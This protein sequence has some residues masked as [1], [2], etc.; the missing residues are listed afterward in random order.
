MA[1]TSFLISI[2]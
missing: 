2:Y 1:Q